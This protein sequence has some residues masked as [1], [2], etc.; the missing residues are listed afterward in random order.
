MEEMIS[1]VEGFFSL[2]WEEKVKYASD[3]V[4][5]PVRY[6]TS[7]NT[8]VAHVRHWRDYLRHYCHPIEKNFHLW[9]DNPPSYREVTKEYTKALWRLILDLAGAVSEGLGLEKDY[10][11][12]FMGQGFQPI[13]NNYYPKCPEPHLTLGLAAHSDHG[14]LTI[15]MDNGVEGLQ[16]K[17]N[18][19]WVP[20]RHVPGSFIVNLGDTIQIMSNGRYESVEHRAV[21]NEERARI[22]VAVGSGPELDAILA[23][24]SQL[25]DEDGGPKYKPVVYKDYVKYQQTIVTRGKTA[26]QMVMA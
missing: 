5:S 4:M 11:E 13:A 6:G 18:D 20:V 24:A 14:C 23:P 1:A 2:P 12:K 26:L 16:V 8:S 7:L 17:H 9:P 10:L 19:E 21:V 22:S 25:V 3:N 15:L